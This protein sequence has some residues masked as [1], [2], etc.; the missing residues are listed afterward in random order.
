[1]IWEFLGNQNGYGVRARSGGGGVTSGGA[2]Q[3]LESRSSLDTELES[4]EGEIHWKKLKTKGI[5]LF[6]FTISFQP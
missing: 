5:Q 4:S 3:P 1:M 6:I 2:E